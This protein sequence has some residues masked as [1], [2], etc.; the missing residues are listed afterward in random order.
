MVM[1]GNNGDPERRTIRIRTPV[2]VREFAAAAGLKP[3]KVIS[4]LMKMGIFAALH[5]PMIEESIQAV[6][7]ENGVEVEIIPPGKITEK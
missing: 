1:L 2:T 4:D 3:F 5:Q 7:R 6:G